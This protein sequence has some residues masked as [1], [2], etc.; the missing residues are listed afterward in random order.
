[1]LS[2]LPYMGDADKG[3]WGMYFYTSMNVE[4]G[5]KLFGILSQFHTML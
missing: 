2:P 1:M 4:S 5:E 3:E